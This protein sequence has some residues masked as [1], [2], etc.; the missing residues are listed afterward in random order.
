MKNITNTILAVVVAGL[1][2]SVL[3]TQ[4]AEAARINGTIDFAGSVTFDTNSLATA[5][6]VTQWRDVFGNLGFSNVADT[7]GDFSSIPLGTQATMATPWIFS[8]S[9]PTPGLWSVGGF[10]FDLLSATVVTQN[11]TFLNI[12]GTG[13]VSGNGFAPTT[14]TWA[15]TVQN[16]SSHALGSNL[17]YSFSANLATQSVP[18]GG[19]SV[20]M[21]GIG[22]GLVEFIRRKFRLRK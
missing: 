11:A 14:A 8:P 10:T 9:T 21:L 3:S 13:I 20:A 19:S 6:Q 22:L 2:S 15:F 18:D 7:S 1:I 5:H 16:A 4:Q 17:F 12:S